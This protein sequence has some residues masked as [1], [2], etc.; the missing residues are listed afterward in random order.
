M[1]VSLLPSFCWKDCSVVGGKHI[2]VG[3][4]VVVF[5]VTIFQRAVS[6]QCLVDLLPFSL[7]G[8]RGYHIYNEWEFAIGICHWKTFSLTNILDL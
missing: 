1:Y 5:A 7:H 2:A 8:R 3:I 4:V 6:Q